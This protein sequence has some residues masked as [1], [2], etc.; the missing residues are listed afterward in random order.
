MVSDILVEIC[1]TEEKLKHT[2]ALLRIRRVGAFLE[3]LDDSQRIREE[4]LQVHGFHGNPVA[5]AI[6]RLIGSHERFVEE[7]IE[8]ELF[9]NEPRRDRAHTPGAAATWWNVG[10]HDP[11]HGSEVTFPEPRGREP[12]TK[13]LGSVKRPSKMH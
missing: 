6:E 2:V 10:C 7:M 8:A 9:S 5:A 12:N 4:P 13:S 1:Q 11:P 3:I